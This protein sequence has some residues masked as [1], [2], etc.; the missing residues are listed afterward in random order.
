[1][2]ISELIHKFLQK[3]K[4][5]IG[6]KSAIFSLVSIIRDSTTLLNWLLKKI[7]NRHETIITLKKILLDKF[8]FLLVLLFLIFLSFSKVCSTFLFW[9]RIDYL[10]VGNN[11]IQTEQINKETNIQRK[12]SE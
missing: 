2:I 8:F 3:L 4:L 1:M 6:G 12:L 5:L 7:H 10:L 9:L 11:S